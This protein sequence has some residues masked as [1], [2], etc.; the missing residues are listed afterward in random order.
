LGTV[1][2]MSPEQVRGK[3]ADA[4]SDLFS[5][6][7]IFYEMLSGKRAFHGESSAETMTAIVQDDPP[8]LTET[9]RS[10]PPALERIVRHCLE[11]N[12]AERFQSARDIA[13]DLES[14]SALSGSTTLAAAPVARSRRRLARAAIAVLAVLVI[15]FG[16]VF[17]A[18]RLVKT[19]PPGFHRVTFR[20][21]SIR[22]A[23]FAPDGQTIVYGAAWEGKP[24]ELF[25]T[26][27]D[28]TD[29]RSLG[30]DSAQ[31]LGISSAGE[32][33]IMVQPQVVGG[34]FQQRGILGRVPLA[35]GAPREVLDQVQWA[36]WIRRH[37]AC[38]RPGRRRLGQRP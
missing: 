34:G 31:L 24:V 15:Y 18:R 16:G 8:E 21:G 23:R 9:N 3:P 33:A 27:Y 26:R 22:A 12:P 4:R 11:K 30:L 14:L 7:T 37:R 20:R 10:I 1:G 2:Y 25:T 36:D 29:S 17:T 5:F 32:M 28:S 38:S 6:G 13:F 19:Q 35:G